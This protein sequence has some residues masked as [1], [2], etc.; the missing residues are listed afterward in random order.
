MSVRPPANPK[1]R[2][3]MDSNATLPLRMIK[4]A[5]EMA[6]PYFRFSGQSKRRA[7]S[8]LVLSGQLL[9]GAKR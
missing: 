6:L 9:R 2:N 1:V 7:L 5:H 8:R 3:P 4:S